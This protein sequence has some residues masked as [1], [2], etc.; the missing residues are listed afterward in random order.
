MQQRILY[1]AAYDIAAPERLRQGLYILRD[2]ATGCQKSVFECF[3]TESEAQELMAR[4]EELLITDEDRFFLI[5]INRRRSVRVL[6]LGRKP[7]Q[8]HFFYLG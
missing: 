2:Y 7:G 1:L 3:L 8:P 4:M 6:G 5:R